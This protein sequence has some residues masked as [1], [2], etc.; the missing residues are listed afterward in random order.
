MHSKFMYLLHRM[1]QGVWLLHHMTDK[2][3]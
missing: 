2:Q 1:T 3:G